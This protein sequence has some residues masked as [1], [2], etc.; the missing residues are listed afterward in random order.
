M[1]VMELSAAILSH[2]FSWPPAADARLPDRPPK[3]GS[4]RANTRPPPTAAVRLQNSRRPGFVEAALTIRISRGRFRLEQ[5]SGA[6]N[7]LADSRI[8]AAAAYVAG[9]CSV[10]VRVA[11]SGVVLEQCRRGHDL[12]GLTIAALRHVEFDPGPLQRVTA[13]LRKALDRRDSFSFERA[14][15]Q[16]T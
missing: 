2:A 9:H 13:A 1:M 3:A 4:V 11:G 5:C 16:N 14:Q 15:R 8:G 10:D 12:S 6:M 7:R